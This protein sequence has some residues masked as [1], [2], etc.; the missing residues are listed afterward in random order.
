MRQIV[1]KLCTRIILLSAVVGA[2][3]AHV[4]FAQMATDEHPPEGLGVAQFTP[5]DELIFPAD[6]DRWVGLGAN[7]GGDYSAPAFYPKIL[8]TSGVVHME[9]TASRTLL[10]H[11]S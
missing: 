7:I 10:H 3:W 9:C 2:S 5:S 6:T 8:G 11:V 4:I 1:A